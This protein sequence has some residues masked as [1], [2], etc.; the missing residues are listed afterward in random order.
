MGGG[1]W[2]DRLVPVSLPLFIYVSAP[3]ALSFCT[4]VSIYLFLSLCL[5]LVSLY[6]SFNS[7]VS[8]SVFLSLCL[9]ILKSL[10]LHSLHI[11]NH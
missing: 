7:F 4:S 6:P 11:R 5:Y 2:L 10:W 8:V 9:N 3:L 1:W